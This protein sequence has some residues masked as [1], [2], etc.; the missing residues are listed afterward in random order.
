MI[1]ED[2]SSNDNLNKTKNQYYSEKRIIKSSFSIMSVIL[3]FSFVCSIFVFWLRFFHRQYYIPLDTIINKIF[4]S[5]KFLFI[6]LQFEFCA[7]AEFI[8]RGSSITIAGLTCGNIKNQSV[9]IF[10]SKRIYWQWNCHFLT[11]FRN[12]CW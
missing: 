11:F 8:F 7:H 5:Y 2:K 4:L 6:I 3:F 1:N 12:I 10:I 9:F